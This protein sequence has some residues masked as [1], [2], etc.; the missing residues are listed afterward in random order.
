MRKV[1][2]QIATAFING[3]SKTVGNTHNDGNNVYL[4]GNK[5]VERRED[6]VYASLAGYPGPTTIERVNGITGAGFHQVN[7]ETL[8]NDEPC[9]SDAWYRIQ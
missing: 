9:D 4:F 8:L 1:T 2:K 3:Q 5:I 6:G 7:H